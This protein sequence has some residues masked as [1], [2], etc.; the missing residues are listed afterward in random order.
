MGPA[1]MLIYLLIEGVMTTS[2]LNLNRMTISHVNN[3]LSHAVL[4]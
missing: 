3:F 1:A 4:F 2:I